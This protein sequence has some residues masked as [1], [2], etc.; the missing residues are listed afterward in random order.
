MDELH[1]LKKIG[2]VDELIEFKPNFACYARE[3]ECEKRN[4]GIELMKQKG[5]S[6]VL[7]MDSD[8]F[9]DPEQFAYA[10]DVI[11]K[12]KYL[13]TYC[14]YVN[15]FKNFE[16]YLKYPFVPFVP[17]ICSTYFKF[18]YEGAAPGPSDPTR[19]VDNPWNLATYIFEPEEIRM[20]HLSWCRKDIRKKLINWS[21]KNHFSEELIEKAVRVW[22]NWKEGDTATL[23]FN[24]P[25]NEVTIQKLDERLCGVQIDWVEN[26]LIEWKIKN[27]YL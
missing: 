13:V 17:F 8:E 4:M 3:Q 1:R 15:Y 20:H 9:Y 5:Y 27:G 23:L 21:A 14:T 7:N 22:E 18:K 25:N 26:E 16:Y 19:R 6:H 12:K 11:D 2:L 24:V 10:K